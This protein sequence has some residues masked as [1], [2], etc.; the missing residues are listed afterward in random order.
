MNRIFPFHYNGF[1]S[2]SGDLYIFEKEEKEMRLY[3]ITE[4]DTLYGQRF[5]N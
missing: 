2:H 1:Y 3:V 5:G 4:D